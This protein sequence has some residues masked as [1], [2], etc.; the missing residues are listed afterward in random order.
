MADTE[1]FIEGV[2]TR[3]FNDLNTSLENVRSE[4]IKRASLESRASARKRFTATHKE[5]GFRQNIEIC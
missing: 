3:R 2:A 4:I 5:E 1:I